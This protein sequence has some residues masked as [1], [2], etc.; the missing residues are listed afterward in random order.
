V[1]TTKK[2]C[3]NQAVVQTTTEK[4]AEF[5]RKHAVIREETDCFVRKFVKNI[6]KVERKKRK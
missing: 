2:S 6:G 1:K 3:D 4:S 5:A